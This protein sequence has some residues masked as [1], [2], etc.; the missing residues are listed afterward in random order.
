MAISANASGDEI[1]EKTE[2]AEADDTETVSDEGGAAENTDGI[3]TTVKQLVGK[4]APEDIAA[5]VLGEGRT[6]QELLMNMAR[7]I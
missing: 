3:D 4:R 1:V 6:F 7:G 2:I 5:Q